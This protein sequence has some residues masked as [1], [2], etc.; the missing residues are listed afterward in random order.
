MISCFARPA[1]YKNYN[2]RSIR[3]VTV[4]SF[5]IVLR[6]KKKCRGWKS[7]LIVI[8]IS[9][10]LLTTSGLTFLSK[11]GGYPKGFVKKNKKF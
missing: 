6:L 2:I 3:G 7:R 8:L 4:M 1:V 10:K 9:A 11:G 5:G